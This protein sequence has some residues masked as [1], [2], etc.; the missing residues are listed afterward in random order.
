VNGLAK[1]EF[2]NLNGQKLY[3]MKA[4]IRASR[5]N[6]VQ[7]TGTIRSSTL[8]YKVTIAEKIAPGIVINPN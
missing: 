7:Y 2:F 5:S 3:E 4:I 1:I 8:I 6:T